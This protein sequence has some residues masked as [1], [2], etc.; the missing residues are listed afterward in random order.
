VRIQVAIPEAHV[1]A[2][3]LDAALEATTRLNES[4]LKSGS[5][6]TFDDGLKSGIR[7]K[8]EPPGAEHFDHAHEVMTR[9]WGDCDDLAP[10]HA[11]SLRHT[12]EDPGA[13]AIVRRSGPRRWHAIVQRSDGSI[14]DPSRAAGMGQSSVVGGDYEGIVGAAVPLM[15]EPPSHA[16][17]GAYIVKPAIAMRPFAGQWQARADLPWNWLEHL[18]RDKPT[19]TDYAMVSLHQD[20]LAHTAL[21]G[22]ID[23]VVQ[24][25]HCAGFAHPEHIDRLCALSDAIEGVPY[26]E[27]ASVYGA[28]L[29]D[30]VTAL[31]GSFLKKL[32]KV[33]KGAVK[34]ATAP[35]RAALSLASKAVAHVPGIGPVAA[36]T[37][38]LAEKAASGDPKAMLD[39]AKSPIG[40]K[41]VQFI[42]GIGPVASMAL[43]AGLKALEAGHFLEPHEMQRLMEHAELWPSITAG[44]GTLGD[45]ESIS[46]GEVGSWLEA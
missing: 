18:E 40:R 20:P 14:E 32:G 44:H 16:V 35:Q 9:K 13:R 27:L 4:M 45:H 36:S 42:P 6:P 30:H 37:L 17:G 28:E 41:L 31:S 12:G 19:P 5:V 21:T 46:L 23:G 29:A 2:P 10:W 11:A 34:L 22:A 43:D 3:V 33:A 24:L 7:W 25:G 26:E 8:P 15:Y 1:E 39:I 38:K